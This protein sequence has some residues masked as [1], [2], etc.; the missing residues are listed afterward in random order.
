MTDT[1]KISIIVPIFNG[2]NYVDSCLDGV[3]NQDFQ[4]Y[5]VCF[6]IDHKTADDSV[7][8]VEKRMES[9]PRVR[10]AIQND[11]G[12]LGFARNIGVDSTSG[13]YIWFLDVDDVPFPTY[14][15]DMIGILDSTSS[16]IAICNFF[17]TSTRI[18][19][20]FDCEFSVTTMDREGA[21]KARAT[22][23]LPVTSWSMVYRRDLILNN[24]LRFKSGLAED[25]DF[26]YRALD[27][28]SKVSYTNKPLYLYYQNPNSICNSESENKRA[29]E[30]LNVYKALFDHFQEKDKE[31]YEFFIDKAIL[32]VMRCMSHYDKKHFMENYRNGWVRP[33]LKEMNKSSPF[34]ETFIFKHFPR[35]YH[36]IVKTGMKRMYKENLFDNSISSSTF[37]RWFKKKYQDL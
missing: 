32:S 22:G 14:I 19:P 23:K 35:M 12:R 6:V 18:V 33:M 20:E 34:M 13:E 10:Y 21:L 37:K 8:R 5:E 17:S 25:L 3:E 7:K 11:N 16:D 9:N 36:L 28:A 30:E 27:A 1:P 31:F 2:G 15:K 4:D 24:N 26:T 29:D